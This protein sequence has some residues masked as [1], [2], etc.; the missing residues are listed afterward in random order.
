MLL[1]GIDT[2][3]TSGKPGLRPILNDNP[4]SF[5]W[6]ADSR[7]FSLLRSNLDRLSQ[8]ATQPCTHDAA[9]DHHGGKTGRRGAMLPKPPIDVE[10]RVYL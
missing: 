1:N 10:V 4:S 7:G 5:C 9:V 6:K 2:E 8:V 3:G